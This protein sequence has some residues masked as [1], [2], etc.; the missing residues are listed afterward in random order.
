VA[1]VNSGNEAL[2][3]AQL[4]ALALVGAGGAVICMRGGGLRSSRRTLAL[5][6]LTAMTIAAYTAWLFVLTGAGV[7]LAS[8]RR[9]R[10]RLAAYLAARPLLALA[11]GA[12]VLKL[13]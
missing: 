4:A 3:P 9:L 10:G 2:H 5:A 8:W 13:A 12:A 11:G 6:L 7:L 1:L